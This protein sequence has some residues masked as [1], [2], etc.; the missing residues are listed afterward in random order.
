MA[1]KGSRKRPCSV[2]RKIYSDNWDAIFGKK[3]R[4]EVKETSK[5]VKDEKQTK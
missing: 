4:E 2:T 1:G 5:D 3:A